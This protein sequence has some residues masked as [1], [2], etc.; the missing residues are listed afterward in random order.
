MQLNGT[1]RPG[2]HYIITSSTSATH[3]IR[4]VAGYVTSGTG[5]VTAPWGLAAHLMVG[6]M[7]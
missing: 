6:E 1:T 2:S 3:P 7:W 5:C 4:S